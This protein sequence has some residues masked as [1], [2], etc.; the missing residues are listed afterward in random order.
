MKKNKPSITT[1][2]RR[3]KE[4]RCPF[5]GSYRLAYS[6]ERAEYPEAWNWT[7]CGKCGKRMSYQDNCPTIYLHD[8]LIERKARTIK[9]VKRIYNSLY[10]F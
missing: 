3:I 10:D 1:T 7:N 9:D 4:W 6:G 5:C 8:E 2:K